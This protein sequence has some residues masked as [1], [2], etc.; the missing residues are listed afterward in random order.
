MLFIFHIQMF[1][2]KVDTAHQPKKKKKKFDCELVEVQQGFS[3]V[4][5][6]QSLSINSYLSVYVSL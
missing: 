6:S 3:N 5:I 1:P 2:I 4:C